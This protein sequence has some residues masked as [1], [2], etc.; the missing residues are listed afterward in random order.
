MYA[1]LEV[2]G[3]SVSFNWKLRKPTW[4]ARVLALIDRKIERYS[5][6]LSS[7]V[8]RRGIP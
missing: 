5:K 1:Y 2:L 8:G 6:L 4:D 3:L 7:A